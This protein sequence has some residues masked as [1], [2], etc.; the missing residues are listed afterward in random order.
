MRPSFTAI[1]LFERRVHWWW[2][3][4]RMQGL[5]LRRGVNTGIVHGKC[6][7]ACIISSIYV[8]EWSLVARCMA[9]V[10]DPI[11]NI[12]LYTCCNVN[13]CPL[14]GHYVI[15]LPTWFIATILL[16]W[17]K[18]SISQYDYRAIKHLI[19]IR[20]ILPSCDFMFHNST[21]QCSDAQ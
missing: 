3:T 4:T 9:N 18:Q 17:V 5:P 12:I 21:Q 16:T 15:L 20:W 7:A 8:L 14:S 10:P 19:V 6:C 11:H 2:R 1:D 13:S